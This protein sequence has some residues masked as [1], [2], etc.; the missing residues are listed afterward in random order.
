MFIGDLRRH[1][2]AE[3]LIFRAIDILENG[4]AAQRSL[5]AVS[6]LQLAAIR[7]VQRRDAEAETLLH[8]SIDLTQASLGAGHASLV[9]AYN[10]LAHVLDEQGRVDEAK[11]FLEKA[12]EIAEGTLGRDHYQA[13]WSRVS[14]ALREAEAN[15]H[16]DIDP[17]I[18]S[19]RAAAE[20]RMGTTHPALIGAAARVGRTYIVRQNWP[21]AYR[22]LKR[23][24]E[25]AEGRERYFD[26]ETMQSRASPIWFSAP[27]ANAIRAAYRLELGSPTSALTD[28]VFRLSQLAVH[29]AASRALGQMAARFASGSGPLSKLVREIKTSSGNVQHWSGDSFHRR[30]TLPAFRRR[31]ALRT[32]VQSFLLSR[33]N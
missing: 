19:A 9:V 7:Q 13:L 14:L 31:L 21:L 1:D 8:R 25:I 5:L 3:P 12:L 16:L 11:V 24:S 10:S 27:Y 33:C 20:S 18:E 29:T 28:E 32:Y 30:L 2:D 22:Y 6:I 15:P 4:P 23:A 17:L 26:E